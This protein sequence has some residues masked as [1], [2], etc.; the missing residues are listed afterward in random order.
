MSVQAN[1][2]KNGDRE[3]VA[4]GTMVILAG[5]YSKIDGGSVLRV[6]GKLKGTWR[7]QVVIF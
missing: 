3:S 1:K 2:M 4:V 5:T 7:A 6:C